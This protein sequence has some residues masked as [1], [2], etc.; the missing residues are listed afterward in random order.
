MSFFAEQ[1]KNLR[2]QRDMSMQALADE[3]GVSKSMIC[4]IERDE[5]HP[6]L[7]VASKLALALGKTL[8][9]MLH[10]AQTTQVVHLTKADQGVWE[11]AHH[12]K[13]RNISPV[14]E[15]LKLEWLH[16]VFPPG[17]TLAKTLTTHTP[18]IEKYI[19][20]TKGILEIK[21]NDKTYRLKK[22]ESLYFDAKSAHVFNNPS[23]ETT[24]Y[25]IIIVKT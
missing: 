5:V 18:N 14:F 12:I 15:G 16:V 22:D 1:L 23:K 19:L 10:T 11:D 13:R 25:Y 2:Q 4:K 9:E 8:S 24:E 20:V 21:I 3:A 6:T 7:D 17:S